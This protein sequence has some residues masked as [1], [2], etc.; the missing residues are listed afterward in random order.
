MPRVLHCSN[1]EATKVVGHCQQDTSSDRTSFAR[2][3]PSVMGSIGS[4][5]R[6]LAAIARL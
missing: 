2:M 1:P 3:L 4:L 6:R 5:M